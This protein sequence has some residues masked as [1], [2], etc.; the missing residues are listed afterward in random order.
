VVRYGVLL[1]T[2]LLSVP[3]GAEPLVRIRM[4]AY[5]PEGTMWAREFHT[6]DREAQAA[7]A[8]QVQFKWYLGGI[9]G[10]EDTALARVNKGQLDGEAGALFCDRL[11]PSIR[12]GRIVGLFQSRDEW[13]HVM[14]RLLPEIDK[15]S[16]QN[17]FTNL[18]I[19]SF[20]NIMFFSRHPIRTMADLRSQRFWTYD[21]DDITYAMLKQMGIDVLPLPIDQALRAYDDGRVDGFIATPNIALAFQW[22]ARAAYY[23]DLTIGELPGCFVIAQRALDPLPL[24]QRDAVVSAVAN[25]VGRFEALGKTQEEALVG[26]LFERQGLRR[27]VADAELRTSFLR[28]AGAARDKLAPT[29]I[30]PQLLARTLTWLADYRAEHHV[31]RPGH[32]NPTVQLR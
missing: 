28:A 1:I 12:I 6:L 2:L 30:S 17:G 14:S 11:A 3:V 9:A 27:S 23:S 26:G 21:L 15:E 5:A 18:G 31:A 13:R 20:G 24:T 4:A 10:D 7:T 8:G 25:F 19:G 22:S 29:L 16:A 32:S